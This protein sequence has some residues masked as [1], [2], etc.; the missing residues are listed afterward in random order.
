MRPTLGAAQPP[1]QVGVIPE[2]GMEGDG[3]GCWVPGRVDRRGDTGMCAI[4]QDPAV[5]G[6]PRPRVPM[7]VNPQSTL[8]LIWS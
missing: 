6:L 3:G 2:T 8:L 1:G 5:Q 4:R 7:G